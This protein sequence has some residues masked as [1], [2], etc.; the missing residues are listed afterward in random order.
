MYTCNL[1]GKQNSYLILEYDYVVCES[2][3][4][5]KN[6]QP[7]D[8]EAIEA[9]SLEEEEVE[10]EED[11]INHQDAEQLIQL[12]HKIENPRIR[13]D[14]MNLAEEYLSGP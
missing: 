9:M 1:C 7:Q 2:C 14:F 10:D 13:Q 4:I 5:S 6:L 11:E 12:I 3:S 8:I